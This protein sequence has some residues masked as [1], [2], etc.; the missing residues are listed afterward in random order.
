MSDMRNSDCGCKNTG[1]RRVSEIYDHMTMADAPLA[2][3]YVPFQQWECP[4]PLC[5]GLK[6]GT[7]FPGLYKPF[8]GKG[9]KCW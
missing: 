6:A 7:V 8:C 1:N 3:A 5:T 2:M 4:F 9:D